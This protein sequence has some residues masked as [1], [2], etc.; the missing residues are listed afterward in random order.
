[1]PVFDASPYTALS[2]HTA[3]NFAKGHVCLHGLRV[4]GWVVTIDA[5]VLRLWLAPLT[6]DVGCIAGEAADHLKSFCSLFAVY[7]CCD[8]CGGSG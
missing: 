2:L 8:L 5:G 4:N 1:L 6:Q 7:C 3:A